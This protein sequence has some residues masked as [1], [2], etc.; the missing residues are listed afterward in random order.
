MD[1]IVVFKAFGLHEPQA[2][3]DGTLL[4]WRYRAAR[5]RREAEMLTE[6]TLL[7]ASAGGS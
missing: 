5:L 2:V 4:I 1:K 3:E 7:A 6:E